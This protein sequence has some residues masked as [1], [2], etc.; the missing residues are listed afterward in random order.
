MASLD[1]K[2]GERIRTYR[3]RLQLSVDALAEASGVSAIII[4]AIEGGEDYPALGILVKLS[5]ALGQRLGTF[6]DDQFKPDPV[7]VAAAD[8]TFEKVSHTADVEEG[9][10]YAPLGRGKPDRHME[11]FFIDVATGAS[12]PLSSHEGEEFLF[13]LTGEAL[14]VYGNEEHILKTGDSVY[15][16]SL[17]PHAV[18][19][20]HDTASTLVAT[21]YMPM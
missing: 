21:V 8:R 17:V 5:R 9:L 13:V 11:P 16:N 7:V 18:R 4:A 12:T 3:E 2:V 20:Y 14:L 1:M 19:S 6:M 15:Y 10:R